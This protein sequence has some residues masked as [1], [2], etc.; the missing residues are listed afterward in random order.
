MTRQTAF[1]W[2]DSAM[3][4]SSPP[5]VVA[6]SRRRARSPG[7]IHIDCAA[8]FDAIASPRKT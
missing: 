5:R 7:N 1:D 8:M 3:A 4:S 6:T 2:R